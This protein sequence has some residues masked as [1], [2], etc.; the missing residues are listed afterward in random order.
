MTHTERRSRVAA[1]MSGLVVAVLVCGCSGGSS[2]QTPAPGPGPSRAPSPAPPPAT[3][4]PHPQYPALD[5]AR[6]PGYGTSLFS[7]QAPQL[8]VTNR[9]VTLGSTGLSAGSQLVN[10]CRQGNV[11]ITVPNSAGDI[12]VVVLAGA[13]DCD[14]MLGDSVRVQSLTL[15]RL[16]NS[17]CFESNPPPLQPAQRVRIRGGQI[18]AVSL[19]HGA[20]DVIFDRVVINNG[21]MP[22][23]NRSQT[24]VLMS[25]A[26]RVA[27]VNS[28]IRMVPVDMGGGVFD[29]AGFMTENARNVMV[30]NSNLV[31]AGNRNRWGFRLSG[32][33]NW[34]LLDNA[35]KVSHH[36][37]VRLND[38][39]VGYVYIKGGVWMRDGPAATNLVDSFAN[40]GSGTRTG[41]VYVHDVS[42]H[43]S[44]DGGP[45]IFGASANAGQINTR[46]EARRIHWF[47]RHSGVVSD[48]VLSNLVDTHCGTDDVCDYGVGTHTYSYSA[49]LAMPASPWREID[50]FANSNPDQLPIAP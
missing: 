16:A 27:I 8:P 25:E 1:F 14:I 48:S 22:S 20:S 32:G 40:I 30:A 12:G 43:I 10:E 47:A 36:K 45:I 31:T 15:C 2:D 24:A 29:G 41:P 44:P 34:I 37:L 6:L 35:V 49:G 17:F 50:G 13:A 23:S 9:S 19:F 38:H 21:V 18:G 42:V 11:S 5:L 33:S 46:W 3:A 7:Y 26:N 39:D 28:L 4:N